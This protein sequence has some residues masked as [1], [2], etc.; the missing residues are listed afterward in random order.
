M[1]TADAKA[2]TIC[3]PAS[4]TLH[5]CTDGA[6]GLLEFQGGARSG[7]EWSGDQ[8]NGAGP[9]DPRHSHW[10]LPCRPSPL[11]CATG[12]RNCSPEHTLDPTSAAWHGP[13][14]AG[15]MLMASRGP[16][17]AARELL[18]LS[19]CLLYFPLGISYLWFGVFPPP[20]SQSKWNHLSNLKI[21]FLGKSSSLSHLSVCP[22]NLVDHQ[23]R[24]LLFLKFK[25][26]AYTF[27]CVYIYV[28][29]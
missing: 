25:I 6:K 2:S 29:M 22:L 3:V 18:W 24:V 13:P 10:P 23:D 26:Y 5:F 8:C 16:E 14:G 17:Q 28:C 9:T 21:L 12:Q 1:S 15:K 4:L 19:L 7:V 20:P 11:R 27:T